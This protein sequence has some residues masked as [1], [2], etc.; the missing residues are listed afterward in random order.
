M[1]KKMWNLV[2]MMLYMMRKSISK[3]KLM[4]DLDFLVNRGKI[5]SK[6]IGDLMIQNHHN[7]QC[8]SNLSLS[9]RSEDDILSSFISP[10]EYEFSCSNSPAY[11][12]HHSRRKSHH[13]RP[14]YDHRFH[15]GQGE[16]IDVLHKVFDILDH[17]HEYPVMGLPGL[18][19]SP[20]VRQLR[21]TDSP[22]ALNDHS[23]E[24]HQVDKDAEKFIKSFYKDLRNQRRI[25]ALESPRC[26]HM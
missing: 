12:Y 6:A 7:H 20:L 24:N 14:K 21:V 4:L 5:A 13:Y 22:F 9:C 15:R 25:A 17:S 2:R 18:G 23:E 3:S 19:N 26:Y 1:A 11:P 8:Y 10:R 16:E